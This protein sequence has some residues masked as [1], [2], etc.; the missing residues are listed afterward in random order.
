MNLNI[1][2]D[3]NIYVFFNHALKNLNPLKIHDSETAKNN[4]LKP[5][6]GPF[7]IF[8]G[9]HHGTVIVSGENS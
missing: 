5:Q 1:I 8:Y 6:I 9:Y 4:L 3:I 7:N 2:T